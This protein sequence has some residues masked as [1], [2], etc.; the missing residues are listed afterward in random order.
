M[1]SPGLPAAEVTDAYRV[2]AQVN[3]QFFGS[4]RSLRWELARFCDQL[5]PTGPGRVSLLDVGSGSG[6]LP[7]SAR[8]YLAVRG[9]A[10]SALSLDRDDIALG[11]AHGSGLSAVRADALALPFANGAFD[12]VTA[13]KFAHH[14]AG[15]RLVRLVAEMCRVANARVLV[16]DIHRDWLAYV[17]FVVWS[18]LFTRNRLVRYDGPLSVLR[19]FTEAELL[20]TVSA[21]TDFSWSVRTYAGFQLVLAGSRL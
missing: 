4:G 6:D 10:C 21:L 12:I 20:E 13:A 16:L 17:G 2:L 11:L 3:R 5:S 9:I 8:R 18:R 19:G 15:S 1:D 7:L 14:F